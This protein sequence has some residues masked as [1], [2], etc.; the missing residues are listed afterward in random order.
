[1]APRELPLPVG[2]VRLLARAEH[3]IGTVSGA[4][5]RL[6]SPYLVS[7]QMLR[8]EAILSSGIE[9]VIATPEQVAIMEL[10]GEGRT[11]DTRGVGNLVR[12]MEHALAAVQAGIPITGRLLLETHLARRALRPAAASRASL[13]PR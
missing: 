1:M 13:A 6:I 4:A 10:D 11:E 3:R 12:A 8:R 5:S 2:V 7:A 9:E